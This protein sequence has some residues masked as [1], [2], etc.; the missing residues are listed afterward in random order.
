LISRSRIRIQSHNEKY[1]I[2]NTGHEDNSIQ[3]QLHI[4]LNIWNKLPAGWENG[5]MGFVAIALPAAAG[6]W[7]WDPKQIENHLLAV[8]LERHISCLELRHRPQKKN[9]TPVQFSDLVCKKP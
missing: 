4:L 6:A 5:R 1:W 9:D 2:N 7:E 3:G 8:M